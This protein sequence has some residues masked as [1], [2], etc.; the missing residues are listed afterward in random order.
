MLKYR[1]K[2]PALAILILG[3]PNDE[4]VWPVGDTCISTNN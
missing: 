1:H 4:I 2:E 3:R